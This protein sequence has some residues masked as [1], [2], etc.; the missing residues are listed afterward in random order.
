M[1]RR[2]RSLTY[3][4]LREPNF[5]PCTIEKKEPNFDSCTIEEDEPPQTASGWADMF[6]HYGRNSV[7]VL[8]LHY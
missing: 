7:K 2:S 3:V 4:L 8:F 5:D 6:L 1:D